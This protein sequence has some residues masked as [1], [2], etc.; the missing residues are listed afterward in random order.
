MR[1]RVMENKRRPGWIW[2]ISIF[3]FFSAFYTLLSIYLV[4]SGKIL[5]QPAQKAY[6]ARLTSIDMGLTIFLGLTN[7]TGA[8]LLFYLRKQAFYLFTI[9][10][11]AN[12]LTTLWHIFNKGFI[13]AMPSGGLMGMLI[14]WGILVAVCMYTKRLEKAGILS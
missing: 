10:L 9:A 2:A 11:A 5:L 12:L 1:S 8:V 14:G 6:F 4:H 13:A 3:S 7:L